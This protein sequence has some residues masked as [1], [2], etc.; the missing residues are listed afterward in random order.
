M[1]TPSAYF[2]WRRHD[3]ATYWPQ[4]LAH[5]IPSVAKHNVDTMVSI[6]AGGTRPPRLF[7][8]PLCVPV[9]EASSPPTAF[10]PFNF[11]TLRLPRRLLRPLYTGFLFPSA[12]LLHDEGGE[13]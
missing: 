2:G 3:T 12:L 8:S 6:S 1:L 5:V 9:I 10:P 11:P 7:P 13:A 4:L